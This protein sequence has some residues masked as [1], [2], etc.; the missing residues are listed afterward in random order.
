MRNSATLILKAWKAARAPHKWDGRGQLNTHVH[1]CGQVSL[2]LHMSHRARVNKQAICTPLKYL[3]FFGY[4]GGI[5]KS[6]STC[7]SSCL[8]KRLP[9]RFF[10]LPA[11]DPQGTDSGQTAQHAELTPY[12]I[13][14]IC[15]VVDTSSRLI[16]QDNPW[17]VGA[18]WKV[19]ETTRRCLFTEADILKTRILVWVPLPTSRGPTSHSK[20]Q[21][22]RFSHNPLVRWGKV[23]IVNAYIPFP[24]WHLRSGK[25]DV[26]LKGEFPFLKYLPQL[27]AERAAASVSIR[28]S[29]CSKYKLLVAD[30]F[31]PTS[32]QSI[33]V[34]QWLQ[35]TC[36]NRE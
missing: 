16:G 29:S 4:S 2:L 15:W 18:I 8:G 19:E 17:Q 7:A 13:T 24:T 10:L 9:P 14:M 32:D 25:C 27:T 26:W 35:C 36:A 5:P 6:S 11:G 31:T 3:L 28:S 22:L 12:P 34:T 33:A 21:V 30:G 1:A 20:C 23:G